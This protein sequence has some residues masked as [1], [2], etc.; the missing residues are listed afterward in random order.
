M[1]HIETNKS[2]VILTYKIVYISE[3]I[4]FPTK[5]TKTF[6]LSMVYI[7]IL[8]LEFFLNTVYICIFF[9]YMYIF[10]IKWTVP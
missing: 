2:I 6:L 9:L 5:F 1:R 10:I 3:T 7:I 8:M 4:N